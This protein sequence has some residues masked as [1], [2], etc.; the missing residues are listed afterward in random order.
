MR[1]APGLSDPGASAWRKGRDGA[2][3]R[4]NVICN[5]PWS[6]DRDCDVAALVQ[7]P[8]PAVPAHVEPAAEP[9]VRPPGVPAADPVVLDVQ[10]VHDE[11]VGAAEP[12]ARV[13]VDLPVLVRLIEA[14]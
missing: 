14:G 2:Y 9:P 7:Q 10:L 3:V 1:E 11:L 6:G 5:N 13:D 4:N 8:P 12:G